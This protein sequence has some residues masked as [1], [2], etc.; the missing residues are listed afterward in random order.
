MSIHRSDHHPGRGSGSSYR[1]R[2]TP[3]NVTAAQTSQM[4]IPAARIQ[5]VEP[6]D[7]T[8]TPT[9]T[10]ASP[11]K[12]TRRAQTAILQCPSW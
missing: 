6:E 11:V 4:N 12:P 7:S 10:T 9:M 2:K 8:I 1:A 3:V 5:G